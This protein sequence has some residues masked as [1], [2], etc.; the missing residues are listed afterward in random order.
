MEFLVPS[1]L[2]I[3]LNTSQFR[4]LQNGNTELDPPNV[5]G[6]KDTGLVS[7]ILRAL[8]II[9]ST[10]IVSPVIAVRILFCTLCFSLSL[11]MEDKQLGWGTRS[12]GTESVSV[13]PLFQGL[14]E[15]I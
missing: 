5:L 12:T 14:V 3:W 9:M 15:A 11:M 1:L 2:Y 6:P 13:L 8:F 10:D 7:N 4:N